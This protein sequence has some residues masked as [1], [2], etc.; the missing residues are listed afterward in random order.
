[1]INN[2]KESKEPGEFDGLVL[3]VI[4]NCILAVTTPEN[5]GAVV[6]VFV[7]HFVQLTDTNAFRKRIK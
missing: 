6:L 7:H 3:L 4:G 2:R 5:E 1:M